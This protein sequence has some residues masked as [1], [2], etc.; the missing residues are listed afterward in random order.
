MTRV[1]GRVVLLSTVVALVVLLV[2]V[3]GVLLGVLVGLDS[4]NLIHTLGLG[5][6]VDLGA[7]KAHQGLLSESVLDSLA[8]TENM[9]RMML[10]RYHVASLSPTLLALVVLVGL[11]AGKGSGTGNEL[12]RE[13]AL[14]LLAAVH[15]AVSIVRFA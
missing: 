5:E 9:I 7:D 12:V 4:V 10:S 11:H 6:L 8:Y 1:A 2:H 15:L 3:V 14:V 13:L